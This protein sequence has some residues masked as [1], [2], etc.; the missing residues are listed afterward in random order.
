MFIDLI[1]LHPGTLRVNLWISEVFSHPI[2]EFD[3]SLRRGTFPLFV[4]HGD[5]AVGVK[6]R[7]L[8][9]KLLS[10]LSQQG[11]SFGLI[12]VYDENYDHNISSYY[13]EG[14][15]V[16]FR[17]HFRPMGGKTQLLQNCVSSF[18]YPF[19]YVG[20]HRGIKLLAATVHNYC[21]TYYHGLRFMKRQYLPV[22]PI[23]KV[24]PLPLGYTDKFGRVKQPNT[25]TVVER[26]YKWS[27]CGNTN[28][29]DRKIM[30]KTLRSCEP[31]LIYEYQGFMSKESFSGE[32]YWR[33]L[34]QSIFI[35]CPRGNV[36]ADTH[37]LFEALEAGAIPIILRS[38]PFQP[39]DYY[40]KIFSAH[41]IPAFSSWIEVKHFL[42]NSTIESA[43]KLSATIRQWYADFKLK[44]QQKIRST[45]LAIAKKNLL[46]NNIDE[47]EKHNI[48]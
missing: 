35:P 38:Y 9:Y 46:I 27:F 7:S 31:N 3:G 19:Q 12:H 18:F 43:E 24:L 29:A 11:I 37:R 13:L 6:D 21:F 26:K 40:T 39:Y 22:L 15:K 36:S 48:N 32:D 4:V 10:Y 5:M 44:F 8:N 2:R 16:I 30:L 25:C 17:N 47:L 14:C 34:N 42:D 28:N 1:N 23:G 41:P 33:I 45:L 20:R